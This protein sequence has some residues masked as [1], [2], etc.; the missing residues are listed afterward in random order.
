M[1]PYEDI[2]L[3]LPLGRFDSI[4]AGNVVQRLR[5]LKPWG[6][7][8][9]FLALREA[10]NDFSGD[11]ARTERSAWWLITDG[12]NYQFNP[13]PEAAPSLKDV[14]TAYVNRGINVDIVGFGI[15]A[16]ERT[17]AV[18]DFTQLAEKTNGTFTLAMNASSLMKRLDQM[19]VKT[20]FRVVDSAG[21][22]L[23]D[24]LLGGAIAVKAP[25]SCTIEVEQL[26]ARTALHGGESLQLAI[27]Q[28]GRKII[29]LPY[30]EEN[31]IL[32]PSGAIADSASPALY[33][34]GLHRRI[35][36][37]DA[38]V[39]PI[40]FQRD[41]FGIPQPPAQVWIEITPL[42]QGRRMLTSSYVF[43]DE[44]YE[45]EM[46]VPLMRCRCV[47][48]PKDSSQ[49]EVRIWCSDQPTESTGSR[50]AGKRQINQTP[51]SGEGFELASMPGV[52]Y[53]VRSV[54][55]T[56]EGGGL[57]IRVIER[58]Q[59]GVPVNALKLD[60]LGRP[61]HVTHQMDWQ[62]GIVLHWFD[63]DAS[64]VARKTPTELRFCTR[65]KF[66]SA[67]WRTEQPITA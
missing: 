20:R 24:S 58:H 18:K 65:D 28:D 43:Y 61:R 27:S 12:M 6:E 55:R 52:R 48:W 4:T 56:N 8:P 25:Q 35:C 11:D 49:A 36:E 34:V 39:F 23:G 21:Q 9:I 37:T 57:Q 2:E 50:T 38:V 47:N 67:T 10:I 15:P 64:E 17:I 60:M 40:S 29:S 63:Y 59:P 3:F 51:P 19:L 7:S 41:D 14:Q 31:P 53:Q 46:P 22:A 66:T 32:V 13:P 62:R 42:S 5:V 26:A 54:D 1:H 44:N 16:E 30:E 45:P 33:H